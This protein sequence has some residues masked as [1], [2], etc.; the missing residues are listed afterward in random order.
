MTKPRTMLTLSVVLMMVAACSPT[1]QSETTVA[2][3]APS[4]VAVLEGTGWV[5]ESIGGEPVGEGFE[6]TLFFEAEDRVTG[7]AGCNGYFASWGADGDG[8]VFGHIG[9]TMMMCPDEQMAQEQSFMEAL[10]TAERFELR[11]AKLL[12]YSSGAD[13]PTVLRPQT[14]EA[15]DPIDD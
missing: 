8:I 4:E 11:D 15:G 10:N 3:E 14:G 13:Q 6:S 9:A 12:I 5:A 2:P 1:P 7:S